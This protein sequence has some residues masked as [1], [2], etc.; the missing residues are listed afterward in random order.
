MIYTMNVLT[1]TRKGDAYDMVAVNKYPIIYKTN[2][3]PDEFL[4]DEC[5]KD[6]LE[7]VILN[8]TV[9]EHAVLY[10]RCIHNDM[11]FND[12]EYPV[13]KILENGKKTE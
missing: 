8:K 6:Q 13:K 12:Y 9:K 4:V 2:R 3:T 7:K 11:T 10:I 1:P 5:M